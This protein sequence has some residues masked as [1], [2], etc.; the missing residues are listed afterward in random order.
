MVVAV[1]VAV[2]VA[3]AGISVGTM[4]SNLEV[5]R[6]FAAVRALVEVLLELDDA[7]D[8]AELIPSRAR[9]NDL[10]YKSPVVTA[11]AISPAVSASGP[12]LA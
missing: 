11:R 6:T 4:W 1:T 5:A 10:L 3:V 2:A 12:F 8:V 7:E 9:L